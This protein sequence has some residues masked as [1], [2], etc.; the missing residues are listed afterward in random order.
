MAGLIHDLITILDQQK[1][2]YEGLLT[3]ARY[4]TDSIVNREM[5]L[6]E[7]VLKREQEFIGRS[8]RLEKNREM[9]LKDISSVLNT[10]LKELTISRLITMLD[11]TPDEQG[12]L[13][14]VRE[15]LLR[16]VEE[17]KNHNKTNEGLLQQSMEF[18]NFTLNALQSRNTYSPGSYQ[19]KG[20]ES[21]QESVSFFDTKQ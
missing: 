1:E 6:L 20:D 3:L 2:C 16:I 12:E 7:E 14:Q 15:D 19:N 8:A 11:K 10:N 21:E 17:L 13:R 4:K 5:E 9:I 18:I